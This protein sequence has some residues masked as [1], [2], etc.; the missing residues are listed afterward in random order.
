LLQEYEKV[1]EIQRAI[2]ADFVMPLDELVGWPVDRKTADEAAE[3][4]WRWLHRGIE[5]FENTKPLYGHEQILLPIVQGSFYPDLKKRE[6][7]RLAELNADAYAI[8][9]LAVGEP[10]DMRGDFMLQKCARFCYNRL[11]GG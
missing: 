1:I 10:A 4:T 8:G 3:R 11:G 7:E 2:G 5:A 9:G 6:A